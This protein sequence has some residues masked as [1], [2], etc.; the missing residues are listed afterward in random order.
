VTG[1]LTYP[2]SFPDANEE[3]FIRLVL[4]GDEDFPRLWAEW[5]SGIVFDEINFATMRLLPLLHLKLARLGIDDDAIVGRIRGIYRYTWS[6]NQRILDD[7]RAFAV[8]CVEEGIPVLMLKGLALLAAVYGN[9][10]ARYLDDGDVLVHWQDVPRA[11]ALFERLGWTP[12]SELTPAAHDFATS[13]LAALHHAAHFKS[14]REVTLDLHWRIFHVERELTPGEMLLL[15]KRREFPDMTERQWQRSEPAEIKGAPVRVLG[16]EDMLLHVI[17]HG[18]YWNVHRPLRWVLDAARIIA[19][20]PVDWDKLIDIAVDGELTIQLY[21]A[22]HYLRERAGIDIPPAAIARLDAMPRPARAV[23]D[24]FR[25]AGAGHEAWLTAFG[26]FPHHWYHYWT[27]EARGTTLGRCVRFPRYLR[28]A[29]GIEGKQSLT[30]F[31]FGRYGQR[32]G[33]W[34]SRVRS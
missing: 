25:Q 14:P 15:R 16:T 13:H 2:P 9:A 23:A 28:S 34:R 32:L 5:K 27:Q 10:G 8:A 20:R 24:A 30:Q 19:V 3:R 29:W 4:S 21:Y 18:F 17:E 31:A 33:L 26:S 7:A 1:P 11:F 6:R 12:E 22:V